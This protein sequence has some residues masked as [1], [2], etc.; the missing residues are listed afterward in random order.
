MGTGLAPELVLGGDEAE[1]N[2]C[3]NVLILNHF[4]DF[5]INRASG[6]AVARAGGL[7]AGVFR[8]SRGS[9]NTAIAVTSMASIAD[10]R[11]DVS[12]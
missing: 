5:A 11:R 10:R 12:I 4:F 6:S 9:M 1:Y 7:F 3:P 8:S 2:G